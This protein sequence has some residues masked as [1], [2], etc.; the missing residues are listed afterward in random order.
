[1]AAMSMTE[2]VAAEHPRLVPDPAAGSRQDMSGLE[3]SELLALTGSLPLSSQR[4]A[5]ALGL[6]VARYRNLV[7]SC[8]QRYSR[9]SEPAEDL[10][11]V[12]YVGL[13]KAINNFDPALGFSLAT[14]A[15]PCIIGEIKRHF[16]DKSWQVHVGRQLQERVLE[17]RQAE[18]RLTQQLGRVP[19]DAELA[20]DL[21]ISAADVR[22]ARQAE[23]VLQP[24]SLDEPLRGRPG[25]VSMSDLLGAEDPRLEHMLGMQALAAHWGELPVREQQIVVL[26]YYRGMTQAQIGQQLGISQMQV[27]RLLARALAYLRPLLSG[28]PEYVTDALPGLVTHTNLNGAAS[29]PRRARRAPTATG[30]QRRSLTLFGLEPV[31]DGP[32]EAGSR[33]EPAVT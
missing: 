12:G 1:M 28:Q 11:Q 14:Y 30:A 5:A 27:S 15:M 3:D 9:S 21:R 18:H 6:L 20:S 25:A 31:D 19:T 22:E 2:F 10:M 23:L 32:A 8:A 29:D 26:S 7:R 16:R 4:R 13:L 24:L 17:V 33:R